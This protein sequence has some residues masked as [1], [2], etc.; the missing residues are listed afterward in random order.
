MDY[1]LRYYFF[2]FKIIFTLVYILRKSVFKVFKV[3]LSKGVFDINR[4]A[5]R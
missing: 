1:S 4:L 2:K 5:D 3:K